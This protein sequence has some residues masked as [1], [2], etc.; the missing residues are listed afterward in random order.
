MTPNTIPEPP[1]HDDVLPELA[2]RLKALVER[3]EADQARLI[4]ER[5][6]LQDELQESWRREGHSF[7][8]V[9]EPL[10]PMIASGAYRLAPASGQGCGPVVKVGVKLVPAVG[11]SLRLPQRHGARAAHLARCHHLPLNA[12]G[13][14]LF[15]F[16]GSALPVL[17]FAGGNLSRDLCEI[18]LR[19]SQRRP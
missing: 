4:E 16:H 14:L 18:R 15:V 19:Q 5:T 10:Q 9:C 17:R 13:G 8:Q 7:R 3:I 11:V 1:R 2:R 6:Q 12:V